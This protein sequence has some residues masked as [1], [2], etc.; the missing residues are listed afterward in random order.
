MKNLGIVAGMVLAMWPTAVWAQAADGDVVHFKGTMENVK[1]TF[2]PAEP[3]AHVKAGG[4]LEA[5]SLD[6]FGNALQKPGDPFSLI[7]IDNP[8]T[9]PFFIDGAE[10]GDT[11]VVHILDLQVDSKQGVGTFAP[12]FG[13]ANATH[14]TP[15]LETKP[16]PERAWY[17]PI[18][19]EKKLIT[20]QATDSDFK[21]QF[22]L[23]PFLGCIGVAPASG[24]ARS[25]LVPAEF[26][27]NMDAP[28]VSPGN[29]L[30]LPVNVKGALFYF[31]DGHAAMGDGEVAGSAVEV[32]MRA[33]FRIELVKGKS[34][35]WPRFE[36]EREIMTAGIYRPVDDAVRIAVVE[37]VHWMHREYGLSELDAYELFSKVGKL[38]L[39]EMVDPNYVVVASVEKKYL[40]G[41]K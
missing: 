8:L 32:P 24:E 9:G 2:G 23:K 38:H 31:G 28:E 34:T 33:K 39:T 14:Y 20:F 12:G 27:G 4:V 6:C 29:T 41:K 16:L 26:G 11:L 3:V 22:P 10:P 21:V 36:N 13:A 5:N 15:M 30:Y 40:P 37:M 17:Y 7:K 35:G 1:A 19:A 18:D 25:S